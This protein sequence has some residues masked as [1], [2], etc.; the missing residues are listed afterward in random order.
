MSKRRQQ[1]R[2]QINEALTEP[3]LDIE[4]EIAASLSAEGE[5]HA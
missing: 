5:F 1:L 3:I 2:E 4:H